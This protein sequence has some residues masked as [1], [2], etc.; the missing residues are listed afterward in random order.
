MDDAIARGCDENNPP[1]QKMFSQ[2]EPQELAGTFEDLIHIYIP[3]ALPN[4]LLEVGALATLGY[5]RAHL[6]A[7]RAPGCSIDDFFSARAAVTS[8]FNAALTAVF[9]ASLP[10]HNITDSALVR[11]RQMLHGMHLADFSRDDV[12]YQAAFSHDL[13]L[14]RIDEVSTL[15]RVWTSPLKEVS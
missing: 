3:E 2:I 7:L 1:I 13:N 9:Q 5:S 15:K 8:S 12:T 10:L 6:A 4:Y 14:E 11:Y